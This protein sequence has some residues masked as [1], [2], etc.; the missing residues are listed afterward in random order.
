MLASL[1]FLILKC[2]F[3]ETGLAFSALV[4]SHLITVVCPFILVTK[5][6]VRFSRLCYNSKTDKKMSLL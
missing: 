1:F 3:A 6:E 2:N 5:E 4:L